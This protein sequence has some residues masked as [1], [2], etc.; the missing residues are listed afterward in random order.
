MNRVELSNEKDLSYT[1]PAFQ[2]GSRR[3]FFDTDV[4]IDSDGEDEFY[5]VQDDVSQVGSLSNVVT[6]RFSNQVMPN[7]IDFQLSFDD[8][9]NARKNEAGSL[10][11]CAF[12]SNALLPC[13]ACDETLD[14]KKKLSS[15]GGPSIK[16]K[17]SFT[18]SFKWKEGQENPVL[19]LGKPII[20]RPIAGSQIM[21]SPLE[22]KMPESWSRIEPN[23]FKVRG[24]KYTKDKKKEFAENYAAYVPFGM[25]VFL[26]PRKIKGGEYSY[27]CAGNY[28]KKMTEWFTDSINIS[29]DY[30]Q[31][32]HGYAN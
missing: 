7:G 18:T 32:L 29:D 23:T 9:E 24:R 14:G 16:K 17:M 4:V 22:K 10:H 20:Q 6:P 2:G 12:I 26:S 13:L 25:D 11:S 3:N 8:E 19:S 15:V 1:N 30:I 28:M 27:R 31:Y 21:C 5:N